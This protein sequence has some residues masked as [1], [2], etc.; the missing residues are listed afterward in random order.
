MTRLNDL[1]QTLNEKILT[2]E[3]NLDDKNKILTDVDVVHR[4]RVTSRKLRALLW[5]FKHG[6]AISVPRKTN[7]Q[8]KKICAVLGGKRQVDV[9][10]EDADKYHLKAKPS[11]LEEAARKA[12]KTLKRYLVKNKAKKLKKSLKSFSKVIAEIDSL[13]L[14]DLAKAL[15]DKVAHWQRTPPKTLQDFHE[16]RIAVKKTRYVMD[17]CGLKT[18]RLEA[19]QDELGKVHDLQILADFF[20]INDEVLHELKR[21]KA[22]GVELFPACLKQVSGELARME[23]PA[24]AL[25]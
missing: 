12:D 15:K 4:L 18:S 5:I 8:L 20:A 17:A 9:L 11:V 24:Y 16:L 19:L 23:N 6:S 1:K 13:E 2:L 21:H 10:R 14:E 7:R 3:K 25:H 22:K